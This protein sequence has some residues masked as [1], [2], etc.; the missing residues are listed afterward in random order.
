MFS[1]EITYQSL[2]GALSSRKCSI[3]AS[4]NGKTSVYVL[5]A[6]CL[7][8]SKWLGPMVEYADRKKYYIFFTSS[9]QLNKAN[10]ATLLNQVN[11]F[12]CHGESTQ[13]YYF[14]FFPPFST[15][16]GN[17]LQSITHFFGRKCTKSFAFAMIYNVAKISL[18]H[19]MSEVELYNIYGTQCALKFRKKCKLRKL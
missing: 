12:E 5:T 6:I 14:F 3:K 13:L 2:N 18:K 11:Y 8:C 15:S 7:Q 9:H 1:S 17:I 4:T 16:L 10:A 19:F